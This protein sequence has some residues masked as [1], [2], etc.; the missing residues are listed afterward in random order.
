MV[1]DR[2]HAVAG[3]IYYLRPSTGQI[4]GAGDYTDITEWF[5]KMYPLKYQ[6]WTG[7]MV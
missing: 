1:G 5:K 6:Q 4:F 3:K 7:R 2:R